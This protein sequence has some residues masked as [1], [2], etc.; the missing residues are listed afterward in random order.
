MSTQRRGRAPPVD[1]FNGEDGD[2]TLDDWLPSLLRAA[3]WNEWT[4]KELTMQL[5]GHLKGRAR[6]EWSLLVTEE[7]ST[8]ERGI[9]A[10]RSRLDSG[11]KTLAAQDFR[12]AAQEEKEKVSDFV[13]RLEKIFHCTYEHNTMSAATR[14]ALLYAQLQ[15]G[16]R[17]ELMKACAVSG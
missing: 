15:E 9:A 3:E 11:S 17:F 4:N 13:C 10:L 5:A 2:I 16:L 6:Q 1:F 14:D 12:H 7:K 8:Y